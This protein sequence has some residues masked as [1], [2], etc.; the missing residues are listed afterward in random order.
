MVD[1]CLRGAEAAVD[2]AEMA[3]RD[4]RLA[5]KAEAL[6]ERSVRAESF[7]IVN[8]RKRR[9]VDIDPCCPRGHDQPRPRV[10]DLRALFRPF[11][12]Q[13]RAQI[14]ANEVRAAREEGKRQGRG[15]VAL[16]GKMI[17]APIAARAKR[18]LADAE[19]ILKRGGTLA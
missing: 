13:I 1:L 8:I 19:Q 11:A 5:G 7:I 10:Q 9:V 18:T 4:G 17:D 16:H 3:R 6:C 12:V 2:I 14:H 15:A